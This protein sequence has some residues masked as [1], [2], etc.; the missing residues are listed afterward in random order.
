MGEPAAILQTSRLSRRFGGLLATDAVDLAVGPGEIRGLI[1]PN[2]AGKTTLVNLITGILA[3]SAGDIFFDR[4]S[5]AGRRP[6]EIARRGL[7]RT[8]QVSRLFGNLSVLDNLL[9]PRLAL[10]PGAR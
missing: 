3:P 2:G 1:G 9:V 5:I 8:F 6:H 7:L 4:T 10:D